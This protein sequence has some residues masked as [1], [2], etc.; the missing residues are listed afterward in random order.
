MI[1]VFTLKIPEYKTGN[2][3]KSCTGITCHYGLDGIP[4]TYIEN[5]PNFELTAL[6]LRD[7]I[8]DCFKHERLCIRG[9][10]ISEHNRV[11]NTA[12]NT[13]ELVQIVIHHGH[14]RYN[15]NIIR[16]KYNN[17]ENRHIDIFAYD[18]IPYLDDDDLTYFFQSFYWFGLVENQ[19]PSMVDI[20]IVYDTSLLNR[21]EHHYPDREDIKRD[22]F[23]FRKGDKT[24]CIKCIIKLSTV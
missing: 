8:R 6:C 23:V 1:P 18:V 16:C 17:I 12:L 15:P 19:E 22:G 2:I 7:F 14:D 24:E 20:I 5:S 21:I 9:I 11:N 4:V 13:D 10:S 3:D